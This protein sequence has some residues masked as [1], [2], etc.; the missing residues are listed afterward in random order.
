[1]TYTRICLIRLLTVLRNDLDA[2]AQQA[3]PM[4]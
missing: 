2:L 3:E 1:V 4:A